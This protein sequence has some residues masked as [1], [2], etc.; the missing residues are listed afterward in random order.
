MRRLILIIGT[1]A[2]LQAAGPRLPAG[3]DLYR[4]CPEENPI[5]P[6]KVALGRR[7]FQDGGLSRDGTVACASCHNPARAFTDGRARAEGIGKVSGERNVPT[8][9]NRAW[10]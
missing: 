1:A 5:T 6:A 8:L 3:L 9:I 2:V 10:G 7:L 4:P